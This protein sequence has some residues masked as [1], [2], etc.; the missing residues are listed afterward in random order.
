MNLLLLAKKVN[1]ILALEDAQGVWVNDENGMKNVTRKYFDELF[2]KKNSVRTLV[3]G[4]IS[5]VL[6]DADND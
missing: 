1:H 3:D 5:Q 2:Q 6:N 4:V